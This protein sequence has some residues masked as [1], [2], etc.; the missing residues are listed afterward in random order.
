MVTRP[1]SLESTAGIVY[2]P[3]TILRQHVA[4]R[5]QRGVPVLWPLANRAYGLRDFTIAGPDGVGLCCATRL[6]DLQDAATQKG[7]ERME[8]MREETQAEEPQIGQE[9]AHSATRLDVHFVNP[10]PVH[11]GVN[12]V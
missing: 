3:Y 9:R 1:L 7:E 4:G 12:N 10:A 5:Q 2:S 6:T 8:E 11:F